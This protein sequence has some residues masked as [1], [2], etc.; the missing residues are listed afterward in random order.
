M[1]KFNE[2]SAQIKKDAGV[3][4]LEH[5]IPLKI[6]EHVTQE[7]LEVPSPHRL[8]KHTSHA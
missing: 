3:M 4:I 2:T 7:N 1:K 8:A 6:A 5:S